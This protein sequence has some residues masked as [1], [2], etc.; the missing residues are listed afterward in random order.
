[1]E[2]WRRS[3]PESWIK[4]CIIFLIFWGIVALYVYIIFFTDHTTSHPG[5]DYDMPYKW[6]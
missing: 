6:R 4:R 5:P 2:E 3:H 1:M